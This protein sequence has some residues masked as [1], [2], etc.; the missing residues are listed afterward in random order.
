MEQNKL[1]LKKEIMYAFMYVVRQFSYDYYDVN[2]VNEK[3]LYE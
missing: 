3:C 1:T 2:T